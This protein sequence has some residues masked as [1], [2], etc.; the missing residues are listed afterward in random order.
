MEVLSAIEEN[1]PTTSGIVK[2]IADSMAGNTFH[3]HFHILYTLRSLIKKD[4]A[5]Y[6]EIGTFNG[7]SLCLMLQHPSQVKCISIDPFHLDR[8][9]IDIVNKNITK[10]NIHKYDVELT[11]KFS[12][13]NSLVE[14]LRSRNFKTD[15]L[16][17]DGDHTYSAVI[18]DFTVFSEFVA[19]GGFVVFDDYHDAIHS[20]EVK[21]AVDAIV[22][23]IRDNSLP[24]EIIG[25]PLNYY[26]VYPSE[27]IHLNEFIIR[28][29]YE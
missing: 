24:F 17:I 3:H 19:P 2:T 7:G 8:T 14:D 13:D 28:K 26:N 27:F 23:N 9:T 21:P 18:H 20:P 16:F 6:T 4:E 1:T 29:H 22:K 11:K 10:F 5:I 12:T 25:S 15:I